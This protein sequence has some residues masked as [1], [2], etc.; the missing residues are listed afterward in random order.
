[1]LDLLVDFNG[2]WFWETLQDL[3]RSDWWVVGLWSFR[4][5]FCVGCRGREGLRW[6]CGARYSW[7]ERVKMNYKLLMIFNFFKSFW[8]EFPFQQKNSP[9]L[10]T[11]NKYKYGYEFYWYCF[12][13]II[14]ENTKILSSFSVLS[15]YKFFYLF[16]KCK[17]VPA[18]SETNY[19]NLHH[20]KTTPKTST[21][22]S[23]L[24]SSH[25]SLLV[26][27]SSEDTSP[28]LFRLLAMPSISSQILLAL[29]CP[30][31]SSTTRRKAQPTKC[32]LDTTEWN[33]WGHS[34][35]FSLFGH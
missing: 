25:S 31:S 3:L 5:R 9:Q 27:N 11:K 30:S 19:T 16:F 21:N 6:R 7:K 1:M 34:E 28:H 2:S 10:H 29:F 8:R 4:L 17:E 23:S 14:H 13:Q 18:W 26:A 35:I 12:N 22:L 32:P 20:R 33:F 24:S 15:W